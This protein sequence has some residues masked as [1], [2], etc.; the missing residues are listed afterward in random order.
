MQSSRNSPEPLQ[1][2][3]QGHM[4]GPSSGASF[5]L[6]VQKK[7]AEQASHFSL[8]SSIFTFGDLPLPEC[9]RSFF[10][11][12]PQNKA[13]QL[14][15]RYFEFTVA[16]H[17]YLHRGT[18]E[19]WLDELYE[20]GGKMWAEGARSRTAL[21][22]M[23]FAQTQIYTPGEEEQDSGSSA[24]FFH[25]AEHQLSEEKGELRLSSV[26]ARLCQCFYLLSQSR[27][28]HCW[29]LFGTLSHLLLALG[30][31]RKGSIR[32][33]LDSLPST[34]LVEFEC[35]KRTFWCAY[36]LDT[37][38]SAILGRPRAFHDEDINQEYPACVGDS[39]LDLGIVLPSPERPLPE[40]A[41]PIAH[42]K[43]SRI[44][45]RILREFYGLKTP[46]T[47]DRIEL[48]KKFTLELE[49][50]HEDMGLLLGDNGIHT[51]LLLPLFQRQR[52][53][54][55]LAYWHAQLLVHRPF[56][57][58][59]FASLS[60]YGTAQTR[61]KKNEAF[62]KN[63]EQCLEAATNITKAVEELEERKQLYR[64]F[65]F[66]YYFAF[67]AIVVLYV[68]T[69]QQRTSSTPESSYLPHFDRASRCQATLSR[70]AREG[71]LVY[72]YGLVLDELRREVLRNNPT[73]QYRITTDRDGLP[74]LS[75]DS[76]LGGDFLG[77]AGLEGSGGLG[78]VSGVEGLDLTVQLESL[79][80]ET[81]PVGSIAQ[82]TSWGQFDSLV[83]KPEM[84]GGSLID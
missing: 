33:G 23:I 84:I 31:H 14:L 38:L 40:M 45:A 34:D 9:D 48:A 57:L 83:R 53:V 11:L 60:N 78:P 41:A 73:L 75:S 36:N 5:L 65:W 43:I 59:N 72:R 61:S 68:H 56:L 32:R 28:N 4:V 82:M 22:F 15:E 3:R 80:D 46:S 18:M 16:T 62:R 7:L 58:S 19:A 55:N 51:S 71:S 10:I 30:V 27:I 74:A 37:Y 1:T 13:K 69:I 39:D 54:L 77:S 24:H 8:D 29:S 47:Q 35:R 12:P 44:M 64:A 49:M 79:S 50:W 76:G 66:T 20:T 25:A 21:L 6:R 17:R 42:I 67:C 2:D 52:N 63:V 70:N 81:S 26:Q